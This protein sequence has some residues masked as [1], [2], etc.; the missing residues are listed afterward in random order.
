[1]LTS[2]VGSLGQARNEK[3]GG[4]RSGEFVTYNIVVELCLSLTGGWLKG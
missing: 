1:M 3:C 2:E 4:R